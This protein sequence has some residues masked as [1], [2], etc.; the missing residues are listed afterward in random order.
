MITVT[1]DTTVLVAQWKN[2][3]NAAA[4]EA[5]L[6]LAEHGQI[7][8]AITTRI[9]ADIPRPPLADRIDELPALKVSKIGAPFRWDHSKWG[10]GDVWA[11][12]EFGKIMSAIDEC[13]DSQGITNNRPDWRDWDHLQGH[14]LAE[15]DVFVTWDG[16]ILKLATVLRE[17]L[18]IVAMKPEEFLVT[19]FKSSTIG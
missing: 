5:L 11:S 14:Y 15:R 12:E 4:T 1:L 19:D 2:E 10:G 9:S 17:K 3:E 16:G 7:D 13:L 18:G 8:L 6:N